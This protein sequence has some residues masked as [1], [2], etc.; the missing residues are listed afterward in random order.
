M[1]II[2]DAL[3]KAQRKGDSRV[4]PP[5]PFDLKKEGGAPKGVLVSPKPPSVT[6]PGEPTAKKVPTATG[7]P[8]AVPVAKAQK[9]GAKVAKRWSVRIPIMF[10]IIL[11]VFATLIFVAQRVEQEPSAAG[12]QESLVKAPEETGEKVEET[13]VASAEGADQA[14]EQTMVPETAAPVS[15][16]AET[17]AEVAHAEDLGSTAGIPAGVQVT[18]IPTDGLLPPQERPLTEQ[19]PPGSTSV[20]IVQKDRD[21][22]KELRED[23]YHFNMAVYF[24]R[25]NDIQ[26]ALL[27]YARVIELSPYNAEV[28]NNMGALYN[29]IGEYE[30]AV[31]VLQKALII[32]P[33]YSKAHN[34]IGL[35]YYEGGHLER[36][37][38]HLA[39]AIELAPAD[40]ESYNNLGLVY[41]KMN[42][43]DKAE[44][45]F[46]RALAIN[47]DYAAAHYNLALLYEETG[48]LEEA[49]RHYNGFI[50][51]GGGSP[52]LNFKVQRRLQRLIQ[53]K[54]GS[55][56]DF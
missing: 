38:V 10:T 1:S 42:E 18:G 28:Y 32:D 36:A 53:S 17:E 51:G 40:L 6:P 41:K 23:I 44:E 3:K 45:A 56:P 22:E 50:A 33:S 9:A 14:A 5:S 13:A 54:P 47:P 48:R 2:A 7:A 15:E 46:S 24:Q 21:K 11:A 4:A 29:Q 49:R 8:R 30:K 12:E 39:R 52:E 34:N 16:P 31:A 25:R 26:S 27:E 55:S 43:L 20:G 19:P 35:V 37:Q